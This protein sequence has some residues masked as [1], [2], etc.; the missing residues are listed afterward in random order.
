MFLT[1]VK[2]EKSDAS[3][4]LD[5][6]IL[7]VGSCFA[8]NI[9]QK[10]SNYKFS[11]TVNP[12]GTI[13]NPISIFKLLNLAALNDIIQSSGVVE[14]QELFHHYDLHSDLSDVDQQQLLEKANLRI[15]QVGKHLESTTVIVYT[16]GTAIVYELASSGEI[17]ANCHKVSP[18]QFNQ[19]YLEVDEIV[20][21][22]R[23]NYSLMKNRNKNVR[24]ILTVS[25]VRHHKDS[26]QQN[27]VSKAILR[28]ASERIVNSFA[29]VE[30]FPAYEI[31]IDELRDY[32]F[33]A[34]NMLHPNEVAVDYIWQKF[35]QVFFSPETI[36]F[37]SEWDKIRKA[38]AH[39]PTNPQSKAH[40]QFLRK[41][42]EQLQHFA[43]RVDIS[44][45][46]A[47]LKMQLQ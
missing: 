21:A 3:L 10:L 27:S 47:T 39:R 44:Q 12:F 7:N 26:F 35:M 41:T 28:I 25:P 22:F 6:Q 19:R 13:F 14:N 30:Y 29:D 24:F 31:M 36:K 37:V 16:F 20:N 15:G 45:E 32:R 9:G 40:Q 17:V 34:E 11:S 1:E 46:L 42:I 5:D 23:I 2:L 18:D 38:I 33:Y 8:I 4:G 43:T